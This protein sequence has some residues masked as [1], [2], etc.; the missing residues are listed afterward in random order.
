MCYFAY[1]YWQWHSEVNFSVWVAPNRVLEDKTLYISFQHHVAD[2]SISVV[3]GDAPNEARRTNI[4][5]RI[6]V[7]TL[8]CLVL[9]LV[10]GNP[11]LSTDT[12]DKI[13]LQVLLDAHHPSVCKDICSCYLFSFIS[14]FPQMFSLYLRFPRYQ[15]KCWLSEFF[16]CH[17]L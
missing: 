14:L 1:F 12:K 7:S 4:S 6:L 9:S 16:Y 13:A 8:H 17:S 15:F 11:D 10:K 3:N 5:H 2:G